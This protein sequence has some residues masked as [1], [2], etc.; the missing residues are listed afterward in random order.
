MERDPWVVLATTGRTG[1]D[2]MAEISTDRTYHT[3][4][5][6]V[7]QPRAIAAALR[8][9]P[10]LAETVRVR[11][12]DALDRDV[13]FTGCG[14]PYY[15]ARS[16]ASIYQGVVGRRATAL[17]ASELLFFP[18]ESVPPGCAGLLVAFSRSGETSET[19]AAVK[20]FQRRDD[21]P[22][23]GVTCTA[24]TSLTAAAA[25]SLVLPEAAEQ[26]LAQT[27]S[28]SAMLVAA[29]ALIFA[30]AGRSPSAAFRELP[31]LAAGV[32]AERPEL[33]R[34]LGADLGFE[35]CFFLGGGPF[36]GLAREATL[37]MKEMSLTSA[38]GF[39]P[40][41]FRHG[42][43]AMVDR[44]TLVVGLL[45]AAAF[46]EEAAVLAEMR[47]LGARV[48]AIAPRPVTAEQA[49]EQIVL[50]PGLS[51]HERGPLY[52][53]P[54]QLLAFHR[55]VAKGLDPDRPANLHAFVTLDL[56]GAGDGAAQIAGG[57]GTDG[58]AAAS[59]RAIATE[60]PS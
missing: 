57:A 15:L 20:R 53:P 30:L 2:G 27:Q 34:Q 56:D 5:E 46:A 45:S 39:H 58:N 55:A 16:A 25:T 35:R 32:I 44:R 12:P 13:I 14:S 18:G 42:P 3:L 31:A 9:A 40:L 19:V 10:A 22:T 52:L 60:A 48:L 54:L 41:E 29:Q 49:D 59:R 43:M 38:E 6:I 26:S 1:A 28:F 37:K 21:G 11:W 7:A 51:D 47:A 50:P 36:Y 24:D 23:L 4:T 8:E 17:P 33:I